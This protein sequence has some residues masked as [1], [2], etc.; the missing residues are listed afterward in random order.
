VSIYYEILEHLVIEDTEK[1]HVELSDIRYRLS[2]MAAW[3]LQR[4]G[5]VGELTIIAD[6]ET[7]SFK[8]DILNSRYQVAL[9]ALYKAK[10]VEVISSIGCSTRA[11]EADPTPFELMQYLE[12]EMKE[13]QD[14]LD[15]LF[16]CVFLNADCSDSAG[17]LCAYGKKGNILYTGEVPFVEVE[18]IPDGHWTTPLTA[19]VCELDE[20]EGLDLSAIETVCRE[21]CQFSEDNILENPS[22]WIPFRYNMQNLHIQN[23][24]QMKAFIKLY[25]K[26]IELTDGECGLIG[27]LVDISDPDAKLLHFDVEANGE[28]TLQIAAVAE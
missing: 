19:V 25:A 10:S 9:D 3:V 4:R 14:Y 23:D 28:Y 27:E 7:F 12:E 16:Y 1:H 20:T 22:P 18:R 26:L 2:L 21:L 15:G 17:N 6:G 24:E 8:N 11:M 5:S 13:N